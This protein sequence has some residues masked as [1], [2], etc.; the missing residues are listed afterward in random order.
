MN[1][2]RSNVILA[3]LLL[4]VIGAVVATRVDYTQPNLEFLPEMKRSPAWDAYSAN[5][6]FPNGRTLQAPVAGTI[7]RGEQPLYFDPVE[8][9]E[10][11]GKELSNPYTFTSVSQPPEGAEQ[12]ESKA[13]AESRQR[14]QASVD[15]GTQTFQVFCSSCHG[16]G[17][18]GDGP[19]AK[20]STLRPQS[21]AAGKAVELQDGQLFY[22]LSH[23][24]RTMPSMSSQL[25]RED[26]WDVINFLRSLQH[27]AATKAAQPETE[28][29]GNEPS[30]TEEERP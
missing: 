9:D 1:L 19:V 28:S 14:L 8:G 20:R 30:E 2:C 5:P 6:N 17:G 23:G 21:L 15:R 12:A 22:I 16:P 7:A 4:L 13:E 27:E 11:P 10:V 29:S 25:S 24:I 18:A 3:I 26:R